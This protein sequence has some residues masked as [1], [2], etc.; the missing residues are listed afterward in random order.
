MGADELATG[1][2]CTVWLEP[3]HK[4]EEGERERGESRALLGR[5]G[6][7]DIYLVFAGFLFLFLLGLHLQ[8]IEIPGLGVKLELQLPATATA[9]QI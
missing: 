1:P 9:T 5:L 7:T 6:N 3:G 2:F 4:E 8:H